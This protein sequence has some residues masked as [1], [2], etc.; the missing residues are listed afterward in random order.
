MGMAN[1]IAKVIID[2][3]QEVV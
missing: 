2:S 3:I 1:R